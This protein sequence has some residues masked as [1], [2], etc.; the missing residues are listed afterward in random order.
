M[1]ILLNQIKVRLTSGLKTRIEKA[2]RLNKRSL[3]G[4]VLARLEYSFEAS[5]EATDE[6][7]KAAAEKLLHIGPHRDKRVDTLEATVAELRDAVKAITAE[8]KTARK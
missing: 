1:S 4:E 3:N 7:S 5:D 8:L 6:A 2:A